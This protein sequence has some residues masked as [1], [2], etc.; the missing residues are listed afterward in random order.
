MISQA[1]KGFAFSLSL[2]PWDVF[3]T[4]TFKNPLPSEHRRWRLA[5]RHLHQVSD[6]LGVPYSRLLIALRSESGE[7]GDRPHFHYLL[8][9]T[10]VSNTYSLAH[11][12]ANIWTKLAN[13]AHGEV[14]PY[15]SQLAGADYI[16]DCLGANSYE[17]AKFNR[18]D[19]LECSR[20]VMFRVRND[21]RGLAA[22]G[23]CKPVRT[24]MGGGESPTL[25]SGL[26]D[27]LL[28]SQA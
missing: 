12:L 16:E 5:W 27:N 2:L 6:S 7:L 25:G 10:G 13:G 3:A 9:G 28:L 22:N 23:A 17:L 11:W 19:R 18:S 21:L 15:N 14:R 1:S 8:G 26:G 4:L 24:N 20:S